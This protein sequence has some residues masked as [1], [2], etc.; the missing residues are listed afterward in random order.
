MLV[1]AALALALLS[2]SC[3]RETQLAFATGETGPT[4]S[5]GPTVPTGPTASTGPTATTGPT[6]S[7]GPTQTAPATRTETVTKTETAT[8]SPAPEEPSG[9]PGLPPP[10]TPVHGKEFYGLYLAAAPFGAKELDEAVRRLDVLGIE[11]FPGDINCDEG[12]ADQLGVPNDVAV[13]AVYFDR[14]R[15]AR[16]WLDEL[17]PRPVGIARVTTFCLD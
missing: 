15:D 4:D 6:A 13:V 17:D 9:P 5:T 11:A 12:A 8:K 1:L 3:G 16:A 10:V 7:T 2:A 14:R